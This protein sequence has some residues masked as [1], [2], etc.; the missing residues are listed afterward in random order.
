M[1]LTA[2]QQIAYTKIQREGVLYMGNGV[3]IRTVKTL[4]N[5]GLVKVTGSV[6]TYTNVRTKRTH[7]R[8]D[9]SARLAA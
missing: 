5:L 9:W 2:A 7:H 4:E 1:K 3:S 6:E 8:A